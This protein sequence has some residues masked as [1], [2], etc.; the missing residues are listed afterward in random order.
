MIVGS[1][2]SNANFSQVF[3][4]PGMIFRIYIYMLL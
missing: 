2:L 3:V 1:E 4:K